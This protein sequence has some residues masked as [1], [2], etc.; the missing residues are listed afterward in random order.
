MKGY[1]MFEYS[2]RDADGI[3]WI[4]QIYSPRDHIVSASVIR[5]YDDSGFTD[6]EAQVNL[7]KEVMK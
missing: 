3:L 1:L 6:F 5:Y 7:Q 2:Y 4:V